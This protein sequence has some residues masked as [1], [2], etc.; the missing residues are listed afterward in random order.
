M[1][2]YYLII[3]FFL[4]CIGFIIVAKCSSWQLANGLLIIFWAFKLENKANNEL[5]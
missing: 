2:L 1:K 5:F 4:Y 3:S